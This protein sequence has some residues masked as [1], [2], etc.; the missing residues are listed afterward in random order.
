MSYAAAD[1]CR[2]LAT[3]PERIQLNRKDNTDKF[4]A[5]KIL[6]GSQ[7]ELAFDP[8]T[9]NERMPGLMVRLETRPPALTHLTCI[10]GQ[11]VSTALKRVFSEGR[12]PR[13]KVAVRDEAALSALIDHLERT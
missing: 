5:Y 2:F 12:R 8:N 3:M 13:Y 4:W 10:E 7:A 6:A 11:S 1:A 9:K